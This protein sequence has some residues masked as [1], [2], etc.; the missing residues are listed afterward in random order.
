VSC[1]TFT[2]VAGGHVGDELCA[3]VSGTAQQQTA[4]NIG[5]RNIRAAKCPT[6]APDLNCNIFLGS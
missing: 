2:A 6:N 3:N 4:N 1:T 5:I